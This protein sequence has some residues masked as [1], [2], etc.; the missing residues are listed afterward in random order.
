MCAESNSEVKRTFPGQVSK[1]FTCVSCTSDIGLSKCYFKMV[2]DD[3]EKEYTHADG[4][5]C[6]SGCAP[7]DL[8]GQFCFLCKDTSATMD[9]SGIGDVEE[10]RCYDCFFMQRA[11]N[12]DR[13]AKSAIES[14]RKYRAANTPSKKPRADV[15]A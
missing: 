4:R 8:D 13:F 2:S 9:V 7:S 3:N 6:L 15:S 11:L 10:L 14:R 12:L 5:D 1:K